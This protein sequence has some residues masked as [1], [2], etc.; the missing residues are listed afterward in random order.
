MSNLDIIKCF[1]ESLWSTKSIAAIDEYFAHD[2][3]IHSPLETAVGTEKMKNI[4]SQ[5]IEAFPDLV[6]YRDDFIC[7]SSKVVCRWHAEGHHQGELFGKPASNK[8]V[9][10]SGVTIYQLEND[11]ITEYWAYVNMPEL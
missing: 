4:I 1:H 9:R 7:D 10:Y 6:V 3:K 11:R 8:L 5:W 2:A